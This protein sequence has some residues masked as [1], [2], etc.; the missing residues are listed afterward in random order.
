MM[1]S[2]NNDLKEKGET[3]MLWGK[4]VSILNISFRK[5]EIFERKGQ[6]EGKMGMISSEIKKSPNHSKRIAMQR[7]IVHGR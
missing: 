1:F 4:V 5:M 3:P 2:D 6:S 7:K